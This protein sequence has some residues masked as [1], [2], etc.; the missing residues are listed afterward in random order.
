MPQDFRRMSPKCDFCH[1]Y[2]SAFQKLIL[3]RFWPCLK[4]QTWI[5][6]HRCARAYTCEKFPNFCVRGF[7]IPPKNCPWKWYFGWGA[8]YQHTAQT[9]EF[10]TIEIILGASLRPK[11]VPVVCEFWRGITVWALRPRNKGHYIVNTTPFSLISSSRK[12]LCKSG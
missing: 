3:H 12:I 8:C 6:V 1:Q 2:N 11:D 9:A 5:P 7:A 10:R 4:L